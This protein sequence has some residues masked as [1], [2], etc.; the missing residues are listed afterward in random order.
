[1]RLLRHYPAHDYKSVW[2]RTAEIDLSQITI[3]F[4]SNG[5]GKTNLLEAI[6]WTFEDAAS[7]WFTEPRPRAG[8]AAPAEALPGMVYVQ[9]DRSDEPS[10]IDHEIAWKLLT[11]AHTAHAMGF[12]TGWEKPSSPA[13][14]EL[15]RL[16]G[17]TGDTYSSRP[18]LT[19]V[20]DLWAQV[21]AETDGAGSYED[22]LELVRTLLDQRSF[23]LP[24]GS[25]VFV[26]KWLSSETLA[27]AERV[28]ADGEELT[29]N[30][31]I[32]D[33]LLGS[34]RAI[35]REDPGESPLPIGDPVGLHELGRRIAEVRDLSSGVWVVDGDPS[36]LAEEVSRALH[37]G[38]AEHLQARA[39]V[40]VPRFV[41][42]VGS[43]AINPTGSNMVIGFRENDG[44]TRAVTDL[45]AGVARWVTIAT[46][47]ALRETDIA[48]PVRLWLLDEPEAHLHINAIRD[49]R[50]WLVHRNDEGIGLVVATHALELLD[51]PTA[52]AEF[53]LLTR[54]PDGESHAV[55]A[56]NL[57][58][59]L[60]AYASD[61]GIKPGDALRMARGVLVVEGEHDRQIIHHFYGKELARNRLLVL[62]LHGVNE[63]LALV[64]LE[65]LSK[66]DLPIVYVFDNV[67][68][69]FL[70]RP[71][72]DPRLSHEQRKIFEVLVA[73]GRDP[74]VELHI[75]SHSLPDV[76]F[77]LPEDAV[78]AVVG[79][80]NFQGWAPLRPTYAGKEPK[81]R[82]GA[83]LGQTELNAR[84][85]ER[86][87]EACSP[88]TRP[89]EPLEVAMHEILSLLARVRRDPV[90][91]H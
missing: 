4:G 31:R 66:L 90:Q 9:L 41:A 59:S 30:R 68:A 83:A 89:A 34:A 20:M 22:R 58:D 72:P 80:E 73:L 29:G 48:G 71:R 53:L 16:I 84:F 21:V 49:L 5:A 87:L 24:E 57:I 88:D 18:S 44:Q 69:E 62:R 70:K 75:R 12:T 64:E 14:S 19:D 33:P 25:P 91:Q 43:I 82:L 67:P 46:R 37:G 78:R 15:L 81:K 47:A 36:T 38:D 13:R 26:A 28:A 51:L 79:A 55:L 74:A 11:H 7:E 61:V 65:Y 60:E 76:I 39:N 1:V 77:A 23:S 27:A 85:I 50:D 8:G 32:F 52:R 17:A 45:G 10:S 63:S 42:D 86:V 40:L 2:D 3:V 56:E 35:A 54:D 6:A